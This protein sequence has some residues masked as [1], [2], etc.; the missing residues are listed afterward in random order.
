MTL[1]LRDIMFMTVIVSV[2]FVLAGLFIGE[3][4]YNYENTNMSNEWAETGINVSGNELFYATNTELTDTGSDL[5]TESTGIYALISSAANSLEGLGNA[6]MMVILA[7]TTI[8]NLLYS[9]LIDAG[10]PTLLANILRYLIASVLWAIV[11]FSVVSAFLR[12]G[13]L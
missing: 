10:A 12:G 11:I 13:K 8:G 2:I 9:I 7:P 5:G 1:V 4:A 3:M 6:L